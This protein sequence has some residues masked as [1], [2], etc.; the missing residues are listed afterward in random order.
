MDSGQAAQDF[1]KRIR[2]NCAGILASGRDA[3]VPIILDGENA[4]E[5]FDHNGR[6]FLRELYGGITRDPQMEAI[7]LS[8]AFKRMQPD[9]LGRIFPGS[10]IN[11]NFDVWIGAEEDNLAWTQLLRARE[12]YDTALTVSEEQRRLAFEEILIAEGSDWCWWY[13]PEHQSAN[14]VEFDQLYRS[15]LAN[16]YRFLRLEPPEELSRPILRVVSA[17]IHTPATGRIRPT[18]DG[19]ITS[20]FEWLGAAVYRVDERS[21]SMHGK[22]FLVREVHYGTDGKSV[23]VRVD[24]SPGCETA[25]GEMELRLSVCKGNSGEP[26]FPLVVRFDRSTIHVADGGAGVQCAFNRIL[27]AGLPVAP[28]ARFQF[29]L[30]QAGLPIDAL[31]EQGWFEVGAE[32]EW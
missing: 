32:E 12:T 27:E 22:R 30:W 5:Y 14:R 21:G 4:W 29:S 10:W 26:A 19:D 1:L 17:A 25:L 28:P 3:L 16:I 2:E 15:H 8:E 11:A 23:F 6:P 20:Y 31:P 13:G 7:T 24:F 9:R 18:I